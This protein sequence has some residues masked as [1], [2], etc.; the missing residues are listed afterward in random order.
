MLVDVTMGR[1]TGKMTPFGHIANIPSLTQILHLSVCVAACVYVYTALTLISKTNGN[2]DNE[3]N[4]NFIGG[5]R[6]VM[7]RHGKLLLFTSNILTEASLVF[8]I[9]W[10]STSPVGRISR[11]LMPH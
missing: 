7:V 4:G 6:F 3:A 8:G 11:I 2:N 5:N 1:E 10:N 9:V